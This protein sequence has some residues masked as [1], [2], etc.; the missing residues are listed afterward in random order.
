MRFRPRP[1]FRPLYLCLSL[2]LLLFAAP[3]ALGQESKSRAEEKPVPGVINEIN[4]EE[5]ARLVFDWREGGD[6]AYAGSKPAIVDF[7]ATWCVPCHLL[8]PR[9]KAIA[10]EYKDDIIVYSIDAESAPNLAYLMGVQA[11]PTLLF[12]P[13]G[14]TP[15][16]AMGLL[17]KKDLKRG[18]EEILLGRK[19]DK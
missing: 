13:L 6:W 10:E 19:A 16:I 5:F 12:I 18:V 2:L 1:P 7:Y 9:L 3:K 14:E 17:P 15:T 11:Y 4:P 8:R